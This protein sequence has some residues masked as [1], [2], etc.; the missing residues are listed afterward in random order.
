MRE[1]FA[2]E[3]WRNRFLIAFVFSLLNNSV[4]S[5]VASASLSC[6]NF[7]TFST[8]QSCNSIIDRNNGA[9]LC[10]Q[11]S[12]CF[13]VRARVDTQREAR[14]PAFRISGLRG[15]AIL[16]TDALAGFALD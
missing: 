1:K 16:A 6:R 7:H 5:T 4:H 13:G 12:K 8:A 14:R 9:Q 2:L 3:T 11:G 10:T 15:A